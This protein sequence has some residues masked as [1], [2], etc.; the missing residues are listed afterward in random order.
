MAISEGHAEIVKKERKWLLK[1]VTRLH[2]MTKALKLQKR[3]AT[4][5]HGDSLVNVQ[6][7]SW[8]MADHEN[9]HLQPLPFYDVHDVLN[10]SFVECLAEESIVV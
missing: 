3:S 1:V 5:L 9:I 10:L 6:V 4:L 7:L 2:M 8:M